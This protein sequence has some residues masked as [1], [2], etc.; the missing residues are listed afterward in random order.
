[1][2]KRPQAV[3]ATVR[4][5][6]NNGE[7]VTKEQLDASEPLRGYFII[8]P[9]ETGPGA[10]RFKSIA[11]LWRTPGGEYGD[12][13]KPLINPVIE[14]WDERG[15]IFSGYEINTMDGRTVQ[16]VQVWLVK[17]SAGAGEL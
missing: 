9:P 13:H 6:R 1:M 10:R 14:K 2:R 7:R 3:P 11:E 16:H 8:N 17:L 15:A 12:V 5:L 4:L